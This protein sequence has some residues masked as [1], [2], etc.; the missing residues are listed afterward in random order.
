VSQVAGRL[1]KLGFIERRLVRGKRGIGLF[2]TA[3]GASAREEAHAT[4]EAFESWL[5]SELGEQRHRRLVNLLEDAGTIIRE[6]QPE[7]R[8]VA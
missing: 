3:S 7:I 1:E 5:E 6:L 8:P 2:I 4:V